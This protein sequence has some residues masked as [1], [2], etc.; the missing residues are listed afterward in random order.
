[1]AL[2]LK[3]LK[4][5]LFPITLLTVLSIICLFVILEAFYLSFS[6]QNPFSSFYLAIV[7]PVTM[8]VWGLYIMDRLLLKKINY[9]T[10]VYCEL[11]I[12]FLLSLVFYYQNSKTIIRFDTQKS[13][14]LVLFDADNSSKEVFKRTGIFNKELTIKDTNIVHVKANLQFKKN[15][16]IETPTFWK[17]TTTDFSTIMYD[18]K[19]VGC[20]F[21][22]NSELPKSYLINQE[23]YIDSLL[24]LR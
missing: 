10:L 23:A 18:G 19:E 6:S 8:V 11:G 5:L 16:K 24:H 22:T 4:K 14:V 1:M 21:V 20:T 12:A 3:I 17:R 7:F 15:L 2:F 13:Y 9:K